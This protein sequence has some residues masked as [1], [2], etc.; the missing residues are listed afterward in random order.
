MVGDLR[1]RVRYGLA[2][3]DDTASTSDTRRAL[4]RPRRK[5]MG[6]NCSNARSAERLRSRLRSLSQ[7]RTCGYATNVSTS[8]TKSLRKNSR[9]RRNPWLRFLLARPRPGNYSSGCPALLSAK[10]RRCDWSHSPCIDTTKLVPQ[11]RAV[12][13]AP[14]HRAEARRPTG[15]PGPRRGHR[16]AGPAAQVRLRPDEGA[17]QPATRRGPAQAGAARCGLGR[18]LPTAHAASDAD[19][20]ALRTML[21]KLDP[22]E[23]WGDL[24]RSMTPEGLTLY[25]CEHH[26]AQYRQPG[27]S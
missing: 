27:P 7:G 8:A 13:A 2:L 3:A 1:P 14:D 10:L 5:S 23:T 11:A 25:L 19:F 12:P 26:L 15:R 6:R 20:R 18:P 4:K 22:N 21:T 16:H 24:S 9:V 17:G